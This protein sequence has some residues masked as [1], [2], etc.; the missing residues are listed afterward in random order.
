MATA[1]AW[2]AFGRDDGARA[3]TATRARRREGRA[4]GGDARVLRKRARAVERRAR[5]GRRGARRASGGGGNRARARRGVGVDGGGAGGVRAERTT[6]EGRA[7]EVRG[8]RA[9]GDVG[10]VRAM[11]ETD[12]RGVRRTVGTRELAG[13][14]VLGGAHAGARMARRRGRRGD[15]ERRGEDVDEGA[16]EDDPTASAAC[17]G[18]EWSARERLGRIGLDYS[19]R[20][21]YSSEGAFRRGARAP[22][23]S[24]NARFSPTTP[25]DAG[26]FL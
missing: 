19:P 24:S 1:D 25:R 15:G 21:R 11:G 13:E 6:R 7:R 9:S 12:D 17:R 26:R 10:R 18:A 16:L 3:T 14:W 4:R 2:D 23:Y 22:F 20:R 5:E 8:E